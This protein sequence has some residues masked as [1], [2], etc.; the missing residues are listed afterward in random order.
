MSVSHKAV[1]FLGSASGIAAGRPGCGDGPLVLQQSPFLANLADYGIQAE[2]NA[3]LK[4]NGASS[5]LDAV[6]KINQE[7]AENITKSI[8]RN[9]FF[10]VLGGDHSCAI[11]TWSGA[12]SY[13]KDKGSVGLIWIDAHM[14]SHTPETSPSGNIHGM[15][16]AVLLGYGNPALTSIAGDW[17]K[18]NPKQVCLIGIRSFEEGEAAFL[19]KLNVRIYFMEEVR[20]R[21]LDII[22]KEA[23]AIAS[24]GSVG[25]GVT[26]DM[27]SIDPKEA[28][29]TG[30]REPNGLSAQAL[31]KALCL[32]A[33]DERF[34]GAEI[35]EFD[36]HRDEE[37]KTEK[38]IAQLIAALT[39]GKLI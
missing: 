12:S 15:P 7:L 26:I 19:K 17:P 16:L 36:P 10:T 34:I 29:G 22:M 18:L 20:E 13:F 1:H 39:V 30:T 5:P 27:D 31:C 32:L 9:N 37:H 2:W 23:V 28:P 8:K 4:T 38:C 21:G 24:H 3:M 25:Y 33:D 14:D 6:T 35:V 11:G